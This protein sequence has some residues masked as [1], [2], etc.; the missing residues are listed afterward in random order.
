MAELSDE[1]TYRQINKTN[2]TKTIRQVSTKLT[3]MERKGVIK[4]LNNTYTD[5]TEWLVK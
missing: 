4:K 2:V 1:T 3:E 5:R